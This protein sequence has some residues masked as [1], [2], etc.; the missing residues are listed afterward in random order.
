[1]DE[2][3]RGERTSVGNGK[4]K[5]REGWIGHGRETTLYL[6]NYVTPSLSTSLYAEL[7]CLIAM[8]TSNDDVGEA[9]YEFQ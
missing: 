1:M 9:R 6:P 8:I 3:T 4:R 7:I 2:V 5:T